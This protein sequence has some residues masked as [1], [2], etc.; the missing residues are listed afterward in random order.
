MLRGIVHE[1]KPLVS[2]IVG[3]HLGVQEIVALV[4]TGFTGEL[5]IPPSKVPE[6][7]LQITHTEPICLANNK[8]ANMRASIV[9]VSMEGAVNVVDVL[10][11]DGIPIIGVGLLKRFGYI[12]NIDFKYDFLTLEKQR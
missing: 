11:D 10:V 3:W 8:V 5:K 4:D 1:N 2:L 9:S 12:L 6:L 7:G